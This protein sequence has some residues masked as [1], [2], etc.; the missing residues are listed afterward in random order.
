MK[1]AGNTTLQKQ[2]ISD[3]VY[4]LRATND[5]MLQHSATTLYPFE[6]YVMPQQTNGVARAPKMTVRLR[7][8]NDVTTSISS[9]NAA[10][11]INYL[12]DGNRLTIYANRQLVQI[13]SINGILLHSISVEE[14]MAQVL[15]DKGCYIIYSNGNSQKVIL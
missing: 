8:K 11:P 3:E 4:V 5:F 7:G 15:L 6:C 10:N 2:T 12:I 13:Y 14:D 9:A 1:M